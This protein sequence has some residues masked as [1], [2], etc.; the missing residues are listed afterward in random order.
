MTFNDIH[1]NSSCLS[2][3][4]MFH[5]IWLPFLL[6]TWKPQLMIVFEMGIFSQWVLCRSWRVL[7]LQGGQTQISLNF[8]FLWSKGTGNFEFT[9]LK[10]LNESI[11]TLQN[12]KSQCQL[13]YHAG[14]M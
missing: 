3:I 1:G 13:M 10:A 14:K 11:Q 8:R 6:K 4:D 9:S 7:I 5:L 12:G 2:P